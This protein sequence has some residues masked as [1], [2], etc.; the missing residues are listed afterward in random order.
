MRVL[1]DTNVLISASLNVAGTSFQAFWKANSVPYEALV[2]DYTIA[3]MHDVYER[4]F[5]KKID[6]LTRFLSIALPAMN[7]VTASKEPAPYEHL[8]RDP[9]DQIIYRAAVE[10]KAAILVSG[11]KHFLASGIRKPLICSPTEF[12]ALQ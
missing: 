3:E 10:N 11:D 6:F 1:L 4:K 5:V 8:I 9:D 2:S 12:L 7:V